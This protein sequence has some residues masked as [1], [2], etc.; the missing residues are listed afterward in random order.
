MKLGINCIMCGRLTAQ[1]CTYC[2][3]PVCTHCNTVRNGKVYCSTR[4]RDND[5]GI[6]RLLRLLERSVVKQH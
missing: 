5:S 4:H 2:N 6:S 1:R 3:E